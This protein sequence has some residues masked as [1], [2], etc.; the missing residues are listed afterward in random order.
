MSKRPGELAGSLAS[1]ADE[2]SGSDPQALERHDLGGIVEYRRHG[3][4]FAAASDAS[5]EVRLRPDIAAAALRT[6][7]VQPS[8]RGPEWVSFSPGSLDRY[9]LDRLTAWFDF[10]WRHAVD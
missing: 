3:Q 2:R 8:D 1:L 7:D 4:P 5:A 6:P 10:A 9:A